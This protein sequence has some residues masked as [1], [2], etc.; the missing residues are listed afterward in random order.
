LLSI[1]FD[2]GVDLR[3]V[4]SRLHGF[5]HL[6]GPASP[7]A[8]GP[9]RRPA[10]PNLGCRKPHAGR[11]PCQRVVL[12]GPRRQRFTPSGVPALQEARLV[13]RGMRLTC[14]GDVSCHDL[15]AGHGFGALVGLDGSVRVVRSEGEGDLVAG[16][17]DLG[18]GLLS[19]V[20]VA[21]NEAGKGTAAQ[22]GAEQAPG[23]RVVALAD[24]L[25]VG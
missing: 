10:L 24:F 23:G 13:L 15:A 16:L 4:Q 25:E 18:D 6:T 14:L 22:S 8:L 3:D 1:S 7:G 2:A 17:A 12:A 20:C 19:G 11:N 21:G 5:R 9:G